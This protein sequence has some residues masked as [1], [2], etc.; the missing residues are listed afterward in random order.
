MGKYS[1]TRAIHKTI[2]PGRHISECGLK[3]GDGFHGRNQA[4][5]T[6]EWEQVTCKRCLELRKPRNYQGSGVG[7]QLPFAGV[8]DAKVSPRHTD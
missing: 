2:F 8:V 5:G 4:I 1:K 3:V 7:E 6:D